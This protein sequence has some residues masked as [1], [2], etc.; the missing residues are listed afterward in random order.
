MIEQLLCIA[1]FLAA[2]GSGLVAGV[3][4]AFAAF[5]LGA[6]ARLEAPSGIA[7]MQSIT[8]AIKSPLFLIVFFGTAALTGVLGLAAPLKWSEP[9]SGW[10]LLGA[11]L[12]LNGPFGVT[13]LKNLPL[14]NKLAATRPDSAEGARFW[15]EFRAVW[16]LWNHARWI[17][18]LGAA[19]AFI[20]AMVEGSAP[21][22]ARD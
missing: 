5:V 11:L 4:F 13:L 14:N 10:L 2:L 20:M 6:L 1:T 22:T 21:M 15:E 18:A 16:G 17:G 8:A 3:F 19:A 9:G 7:A 12:F